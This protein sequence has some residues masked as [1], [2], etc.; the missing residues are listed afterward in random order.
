MKT[1]TSAIL[2]ELENDVK[3]LFSVPI[4]KRKKTRKDFKALE[5][6]KCPA[7]NFEKPVQNF[8]PTRTGF[9]SYCRDCQKTKA[10]LRSKNMSKEEKR[11]QGQARYKNHRDKIIQRVCAYAK[12]NPDKATYWSTKRYCAKL[13]R[14]P[15]WL[16]TK[17]FDQIKSFYAQ[18]KILTQKTKVKHE[19]DHIVPLQGEIVSGLHVPWNL[20]ILTKTENIKKGNR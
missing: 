17:Q 4:K 16:N 1:Y 18:A 8:Y 12:A 20:Q 19:V 13:K 5:I 10:S 11:R 7:C 9:S 6:K 15:S 2:L 3:S 14:T